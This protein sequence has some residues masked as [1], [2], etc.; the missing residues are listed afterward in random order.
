MEAAKQPL[1][2]D[3][4]ALDAAQRHKI[5]DA[6]IDSIMRYGLRATTLLLVAEE[7]GLPQTVLNSYF[8]TRDELLVAALT[9][10]VE[11]YDRVWRM[12]LAKAPADS[13]S[14]L[15]VLVETDFHPT[16]YNKKTMTLWQAFLGDCEAQKLYASVSDEIDQARFDKMFDLCTDLLEKNP[17]NHWTP[18]LAAQSIDY[19]TFGLWQE[20]QNT[21]APLSRQQGLNIVLHL[22]SS[23]FPAYAGLI[24]DHMQSEKGG[25]GVPIPLTAGSESPGALS[26]ETEPA[27]NSLQGR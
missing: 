13:M 18:M 24:K 4:P 22:V 7:A 17:N 3:T 14:M 1:L 8:K 11:H 9:Y 25:M 21:T 10:S 20:L 19:L 15:V 16:I 26:E 2:H 23:I 12:N 5:I 6:T 27:A